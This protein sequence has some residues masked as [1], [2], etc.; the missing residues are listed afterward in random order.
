MNYLVRTLST[1]STPPTQM[2]SNGK[3]GIKYKLAFDRAITRKSPTSMLIM[4]SSGISN[5]NE[6]K[7]TQ[8]PSAAQESTLYVYAIMTVTETYLSD[9][10]CTQ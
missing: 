3:E 8:M 6:L 5:S 9:H 2:D 10:A 4:I 1:P 7:W